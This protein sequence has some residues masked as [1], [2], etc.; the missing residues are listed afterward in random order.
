LITSAWSLS[1]LKRIKA[2][3]FGT[4]AVY[5]NPAYASYVKMYFEFD[6]A[7]KVLR[8]AGVALQF[9]KPD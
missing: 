4:D 6:E 5:L 3:E 9:K 8:H 2:L 7:K 1:R